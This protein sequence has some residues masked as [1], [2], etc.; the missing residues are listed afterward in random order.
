[1]RLLD[2]AT[3]QATPNTVSQ[4]WFLFIS[5]LKFVNYACVCMQLPCNFKMKF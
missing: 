4:H 3:Q 2:I 5:L 1:M